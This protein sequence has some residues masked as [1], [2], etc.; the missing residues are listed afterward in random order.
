MSR[1]WNLVRKQN[2]W[3][4]V[5]GELMLEAKEAVKSGSAERDA[6]RADL[7][8]FV[9]QSPDFDNSIPVDKFDELASRLHKKLVQADLEEEL[10][11]LEGRQPVFTGILAEIREVAGEANEAADMI[12]LN[13]AR[14]VVDSVVDA[15]DSLKEI[16]KSIDAKDAPKLAGSLD[17]MLAAFETVRK[18]LKS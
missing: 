13:R 2:I 1:N 12:S 8:E 7:R 10:A 9:D 5:L 4:E 17:E 16:R 18:S 14:K 6:V 3:E 11:K 15:M